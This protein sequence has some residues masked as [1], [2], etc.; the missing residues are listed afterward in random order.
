[1]SPKEALLNGS[2]AASSG[3]W[4]R[5]KNKHLYR[6]FKKTQHSKFPNSKLTKFTCLHLAFLPHSA[7]QSRARGYAE[8]RR[9]LPRHPLSRHG[10][11]SRAGPVLWDPR[12]EPLL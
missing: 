9:S 6:K 7:Q 1:M 12:R 11:L 8:D 5:L 10:H 4:G 2:A 3:G